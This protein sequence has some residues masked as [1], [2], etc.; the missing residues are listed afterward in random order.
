MSSDSF[1]WNN[2]ERRHGASLRGGPGV[3]MSRLERLTGDIEVHT[4][5]T[6]MRPQEGEGEK[7]MMDVMGNDDETVTEAAHLSGGV[8]AIDMRHDLIP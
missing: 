7:T 4:E 6:E 8:I 2:L 1:G 3:E 5:S